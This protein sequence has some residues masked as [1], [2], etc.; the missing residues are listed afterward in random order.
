M[1]NCVII[2]ESVYWID[3]D[4]GAWLQC[5]YCH[6]IPVTPSLQSS[7]HRGAPKYQGINIAT[8]NYLKEIKILF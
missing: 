8:L 6:D 3:G 2:L 4:P 1:S 7:S 5:C